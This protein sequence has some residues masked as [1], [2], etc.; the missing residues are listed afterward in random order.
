MGK[1]VAAVVQAAPIPGDTAASVA[2]CVE[3]IAETARRGAKLAVF[4]EAFIGGYPKGADFHIFVGARTAEGRQEFASYWAR[5]MAV[6]CIVRH[7][8]SVRTARCSASTAS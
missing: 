7:S 2:K 1:F 4:P 3:L 5:A 8:T 6:R